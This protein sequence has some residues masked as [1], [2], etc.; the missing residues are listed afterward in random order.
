MGSEFAFTISIRR[1]VTTM[2]I[3]VA[4]LIIIHEVVA[5]KA[6]Q[7]NVEEMKLGQQH[8]FLRM[9]DLGSESNIP[10][11]YQTTTIALSGYLLWFIAS[12][13]RSTGDQ[14]AWF[15][16]FMSIVFFFLSADE[17]AGF[18]EAVGSVLEKIMPTGGVLSYGWIIPYSLLGIGFL[19]I[20]WRFLHSLEPRYRRLLIA[21]GIVY[22]SGAVGME[23]V[24]AYF[25]NIV[26]IYSPIG[27][28]LRAVEEGLEM[29]GIL[30]FNYS[31]LTY[32]K[33]QLPQIFFRVDP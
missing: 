7:G 12:A 17:A 8:G 30:F 33:E 5:L 20:I 26:G 11:W 4:A 14:F 28:S 9:F 18:H 21:S 29:F 10:T 3:V 27:V 1:V 6:V 16:G 25:D 31:L 22:V 32:I 2:A 23:M 15:W 13:K 19:V 24:E